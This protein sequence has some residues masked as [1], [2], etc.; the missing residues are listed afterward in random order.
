MNVPGAIAHHAG[1]VDGAETHIH[2]LTV[3]GI[4]GAF[5]RQTIGKLWFVEDTTAQGRVK[6]RATRGIAEAGWIAID[7]Q[8]PA[9]ERGG[10][11]L[12]RQGVV[13]RAKGIEAGFGHHRAPAAI[14]PGQDRTHAG[15]WRAGEAGGGQPKV[16]HLPCQRLGHRAFDLEF[17]VAGFRQAEAIVARHKADGTDAVHRH[18]AA[19]RC[20]LPYG[21][22]HRIGNGGAR[23]IQLQHQPA[24]APDLSHRDVETIGNTVDGIDGLHRA[25]QATGA[26]RGHE[27]EIG[28]IDV[29]HRLREADAERL[30]GAVTFAPRCLLDPHQQRPHAINQQP[31][32]VDCRQAAVHGHAHAAIAI[33][34]AAAFWQAHTGGQTNAAGAAQ[35]AV[36]HGVGKAEGSTGG[37]AGLQGL[38]NGLNAA[39]ASELQAQARQATSRIEADGAIKTDRE[40]EHGTR[41]V[42]ARSRQLDTGD[43]GDIRHRC[44]IHRHRHRCAGL[45]TA[46]VAG[47]Q[48]ERTH[49]IAINIPIRGPESLGRAGDDGIAAGNPI[50]GGLGCAAQFQAAAGQRLHHIGR[51]VPVD[52]TGVGH[53]RQGLDADLGSGVFLATHHSAAQERER[54]CIIDRCN[55]ETTRGD[56]ACGQAAIAHLPLNRS[57]G[58]RGSGVLAAAGVGHRAQRP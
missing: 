21:V 8:V 31:G 46:V 10:A 30:L 38:Q 11:L 58:V 15:Q 18:A 7:R 6:G 39:V 17:G 41:A 36:N 12:E 52:I 22:A 2:E 37:V 32:A 3:F 34:E 50:R 48:L 57:G 4:S 29:A 47:H 35:I 5:D 24:Q 44:H 49:A 14:A 23:S 13:V 42:G 20:P 28:G 55:R 53:A 27:A 56:R 9:A 33:G 51:H 40:L 26:A 54:G 19:G 43:L 45:G 16:Q 25:N 1:C